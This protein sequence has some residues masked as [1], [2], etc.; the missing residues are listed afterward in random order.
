MSY[1][2]ALV[3]LAAGASSRMGRPKPLLP[4]SGTTMIGHVASVCSQSNVGNVYV[5]VGAE[6]DEVE[7]ALSMSGTKIVQNA[8]WRTGL[9]SSI[10]AGLRATMAEDPE[11]DAVLICL[12]DQPGVRGA[13]LVSIAS[14]LSD[15]FALAASQYDDSVGVPALI[16]R[17]YF[18]ELLALSG[19]RG[20]K[21]LLMKHRDKVRAFPMD[22][23]A[24]DIDTP[25]DYAALVRDDR[26]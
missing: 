4:Y 20:A 13:D 23:A 18:D 8:H 6:S 21:A 3:I 11:L 22:H 16:G 19:D 12:G 25:E 9:A 7:K 10:H 26:P 24:R 15:G 14:A 5:V 2:I 1:R 17:A